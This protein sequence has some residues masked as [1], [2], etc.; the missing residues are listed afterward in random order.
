MVPD[1]ALPPWR[2]VRGADDDSGLLTGS[3]KTS[4]PALPAQSAETTQDK[5]FDSISSSAKSAPEDYDADAEDEAYPYAFAILEWQLASGSRG[6]LHL[7]N[8]DNQALHCGRV[9][10]L[11]E[12]GTGLALAA[13]A[14][15]E[16]SPRCWNALP[17]AARAWWSDSTNVSAA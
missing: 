2:E 11:P 10:R 4:P 12:P 8:D 6:K 15:R 9:L 16:W 14:G 5:V 17:E 13:N 3:A 1:K 7:V